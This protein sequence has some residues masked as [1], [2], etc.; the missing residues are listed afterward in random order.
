MTSLTLF[1]LCRSSGDGE[2][3]PV[4]LQCAGEHRGGANPPH[5]PQV[6]QGQ[7]LRQRAGE[8]HSHG[9]CGDGSRPRQLPQ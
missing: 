8:Q 6:Q 7:V 5:R 4:C 9:H 3:R 1:L 2:R